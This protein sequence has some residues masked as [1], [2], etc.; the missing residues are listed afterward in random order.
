MRR[1]TLQCL[2]ILS[3]RVDVLKDRTDEAACTGRN[4]TLQKRRFIIVGFLTCILVLYRLS[5]LMFTVSFP[6]S[7]QVDI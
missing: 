3:M 7:F 2:Y 6:Q 5:G 4:L 1:C